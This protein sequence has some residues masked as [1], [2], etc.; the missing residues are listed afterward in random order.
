MVPITIVRNENFVAPI[1]KFLSS[2]RLG[3][4]LIALI[5]I[6]C[7][8]GSIIGADA[9][10]GIDFGR[11]YIFHTT[12]FLGLMGLLLVNLVLCSWEKSYIALTL[13]QKKN[14]IATPAFYEAS[15][16]SATITP[17]PDAELVDQELRRFYS[18][19]HRKGAAWYS[20]RGLL[21]R[22]GATIIHIGLLWTMTA[23]F[24]RILADDLGFGVFDSTIVLPEAESHATYF[25]RIDR[26]KGSTS[27]NLRQRQMPFTLRNLDF[28]A[29]YHPNSSVARYYSTLIELRDGD[30]TQIAEV[31]MTNPLKYKGFKVTQNSFS[32]SDRIIRGHYR[33][34]DMESGAA[35]ELDASPGDPVR[36]LLPK[37]QNLF[38]QIDHFG[39]NGTFQILDLAAKNVIATGA[40]QSEILPPRQGD[41]SPSPM[42]ALEQE[43][44]TSKYALLP[45]ALFPN[46]RI[47]ESGQPTTSDDKFD[48][49]A[50]LIMFFKNGKSNGAQWAF[51]RPE[52]QSIAGQ[53]HPEMAVQFVEYRMREG[54]TGTGGLMDYEIKLLVSQK[55]PATTLGEFWVKPGSLLELKEV[56][57]SLLDS[58]LVSDVTT[59]SA[60]ET[61]LTT[62]TQQDGG[63]SSSAAA[64]GGENARYRV[65]YLGTVKGNV[66]FLGF[67][68]DPSVLWLYTGSIIILIGA[69][70]AFLIPYRETWAFLDEKS[71][72]LLLATRVRGT[73]PPAHRE[74]DRLVH[75]MAALADSQKVT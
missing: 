5:A 31:N 72:A 30:H 63:A 46:F 65:T 56:S 12:W 22:C 59:T 27:D 44:A 18:V 36:V 64:T 9:H 52:A 29:D 66:S 53:V 6:A 34:T 37:S 21:G 28:R 61:E 33:V 40:V 15:Q 48:N 3:I 73:S 24:Y 49:P 55:D 14:T 75:R 1:L 50:T 10:M 71:G 68:K 67:M 32:D 69:M 54:A 45:A 13:R 11:E 51:L 60:S 16:H 25:T 4:V 39:P 20:Q 62:A 38:F 43:L 35:V 70:M 57:P 47:D 41:N 42:A 8:A 7:I 74:F 26:L 19:T 2:L 17:A 23:G 58:P